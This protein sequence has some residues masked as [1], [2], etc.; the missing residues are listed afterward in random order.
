M[1]LYFI[2]FSVWESDGMVNGSAFLEDFGEFHGVG[3]V[4]YLIGW[5]AS[6]HVP[7]QLQL[8]KVRVS[9]E[10]RD[11]LRTAWDGSHA[12]S[13]LCHTKF[14]DKVSLH[15]RIIALPVP[16]EPFPLHRDLI[17][18]SCFIPLTK[19][20]QRCLDSSSSSPSPES[21]ST[22]STVVY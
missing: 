1:S 5:L 17:V 8:L 16:L 12:N 18:R 22:S 14:S 20:K 2:R 11:R 9:L 3:G 6:V 10:A 15:S 4:I 21:A 7:V 13:H 19:S